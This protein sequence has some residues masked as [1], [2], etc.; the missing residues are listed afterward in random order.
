MTRSSPASAVTTLPQG[1]ALIEET[2]FQVDMKMRALS[3]GIVRPA[4][5]SGQ[6]VK[7]GGS[8]APEAKG[9][10]D[11]AGSGQVGQSKLET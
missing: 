4:R 11:V 2:G 6:P 3:S 7:A 9:R 1:A 10:A 5:L 8:Y